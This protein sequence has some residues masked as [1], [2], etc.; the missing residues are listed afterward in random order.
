MNPA[1]TEHLHA[2]RHIRGP[3]QGRLLAE[4]RTLDPSLSGMTRRELAELLYRLPGR[5]EARRVRNRATEPEAAAWCAAVASGMTRHDV[6]R[7]PT[8]NPRRVCLGVVLRVTRGVQSPKQAAQR[9]P[10]PPADQL[11]AWHDAAMRGWTRPQIQADPVLNP[12][13]GYTL[14]AIKRFMR[15][16]F[17]WRGYTP[18]PAQYRWMKRDTERLPARA[19]RRLT[20][21]EHAQVHALRTQGVGVRRAAQQLGLPQ[22]LVRALYP[23][24][25]PPERE[26][27]IRAAFEAHGTLAACMKAGGVRAPIVRALLGIPP[28]MGL[29][30]AWLLCQVPRWRADLAS[31]LSLREIGARDHVSQRMLRWALRSAP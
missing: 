21:E 30:R 2:N 12:G 20:A 29:R 23:S 26:R 1:A 7:D 31:N 3:T 24:R 13:R 25:L 4:L 17:R 8:L 16:E 10:R 15:G 6:H 11:A 19:G 18:R 27:A 28:G 22:D 9:V 5:G 14:S